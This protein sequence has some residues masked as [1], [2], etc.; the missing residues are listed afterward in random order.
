[1]PNFDFQRSLVGKK[2]KIYWPLEENWYP[3]KVTRYNAALSKFKVEY[4]VRGGTNRD[5]CTPTLGLVPLTS[6]VP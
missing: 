2:V 4:D 5:L 1:V 3:G 6:H